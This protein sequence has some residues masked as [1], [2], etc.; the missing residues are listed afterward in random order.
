[1]WM[2]LVLLLAVYLGDMVNYWVGSRFG[3]LLRRK[4]YFK[5]EHMDA[6]R[7][8][9]TKYGV[10]ILLL[11]KFLP[12]VKALVPVLAGTGFVKFRKFLAVSAVA[13]LLWIGVFFLGGY[14][15]TTRRESFRSFLR[16][17]RGYCRVHGRR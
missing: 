5:K 2:F 15:H 17:V 4:N 7:K 1:M 6:A 10:E 14:L 3:R 11:A 16:E 13:A 12:F 9:Y 8:S